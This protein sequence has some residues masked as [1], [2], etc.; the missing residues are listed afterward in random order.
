M[1]DDIEASGVLPTI[2]RIRLS[3]PP[4]L[5]QMVPYLIGFEPASSLVLIGLSPPRFQVVVTCRVDVGTPIEE[6]TSWFRAAANAGADSFVA[7]VYDDQ[8]GPSVPDFSSAPSMSHSDFIAALES[9]AS[10]HGLFMVDA[11]LVCDRRWWSYTCKNPDCCPPDGTPMETTGA[12]AAAA[13]SHGM[14]AAADREDLVREV[15]A[16]PEG[17]ASIQ[18]TIDG[19]SDADFVSWTSGH[20]NGPARRHLRQA[21]SFVEEQVT[22]FR[23][24]RVPPSDRDAARVLLSLRNIRIRDAVIATCDVAADSPDVDFWRFLTRV[25][26]SLLVAPPATIYALCA[27]G[28][29]N[30]ARA[31]VGLDRVFDDE[32]DY[33]LAHLLAQALQHGI[34]PEIVTESLLEGGRRERQRLFRTGRRKAT[35]RAKSKRRRK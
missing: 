29:G 32:P 4:E 20:L 28:A 10:E 35:N 7:V 26:P 30:G 18:E 9:R 21:V 34:G 33:R 22:L 14:V 31:N 2:E 27:Y 23:E 19:L 5:L 6:L 11:L 3:G 24:T 15:A 17:V 25:A 8:A 13:V 12:V 1:T 16:D